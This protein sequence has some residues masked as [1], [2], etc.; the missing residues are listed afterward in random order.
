MTCFRGLTAAKDGAA[1]GADHQMTA[2]VLRFDGDVHVDVRALADAIAEGEFD[3]LGL[4]GA[5]GLRALRS[6]YPTCGGP[7]SHSARATFPP[8]EDAMN[9][10]NVS[11]AAQHSQ[12]RKMPKPVKLDPLGNRTTDIPDGAVHGG[13]ETKPGQME[14]DEDIA[15]DAPQS[16][17]ERTQKTGR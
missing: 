4:N 10:P 12:D 7:S 17:I 3:D 9:E 15:A 14:G 8:L 1:R 13:E 6:R 11:N 5:T 16:E 2:F